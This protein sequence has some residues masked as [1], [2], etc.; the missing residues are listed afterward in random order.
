MA[1]LLEQND[2]SKL[3]LTAVNKLLRSINEPP[4]ATEADIDQLLEATTAASTLIETKREVLSMDWDF[5]TDIGWAFPPDE[6]GYITIPANVLDLSASDGDLIMRDWRLYSRSAQ[7]ALFDEAQKLDVVWDM[8][9]NSLTHPI[10]NYV[11]IRAM[12]IFQAEQIM[13]TDIYQYTASDE[14]TAY[15]IARRSEGRTK[16]F[17]MLNSTYGTTH[18]IGRS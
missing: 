1:S 2:S 12:R 6:Q 17:N 7:S 4:I 5:N 13:D 15:M 8:D 11:T 10:R 3:F 16:K 9:F 14:E 18:N